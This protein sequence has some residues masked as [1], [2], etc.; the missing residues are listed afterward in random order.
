[1]YFSAG[2]SEDSDYTS[3]FN[4]PVNGQI[5]NAAT[6]QYLP[7]ALHARGAAS[8]ASASDHPYR[9]QEDPFEV[10]FTTAIRFSSAVSV[11]YWNFSTFK[12]RRGSAKALGNGQFDPGGQARGHSPRPKSL[13]K[14]LEN[15]SSLASWYNYAGAG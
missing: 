7:V 2:F 10:S 8:A 4:F 13:E 1:M 3:D 15:P 9:G 12:D 5:P 11:F 14:D 6:S